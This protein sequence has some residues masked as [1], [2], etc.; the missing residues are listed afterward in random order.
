[1]PIREF[2]KLSPVPSVTSYGSTNDNK[3]DSN[4]NRKSTKLNNGSNKN[5]KLNGNR[6]DSSSSLTSN[7][8]IDSHIELIKSNNKR[9]DKELMSDINNI[10]TI[11]SANTSTTMSTINH[12]PSNDET[13]ILKICDLEYTTRRSSSTS[14]INSIKSNPDNNKIMV[15]T[16]IRTK[17]D[18]HPISSSPKRHH[19]SLSSS[20]VTSS[21]TT[22]ATSTLDLKSYQKHSPRNQHS[23]NKCNCSSCNSK[24]LTLDK[25][26]KTKSVG[27]Q[28]NANNAYDPWIKQN[29][30]N[31]KNGNC[32]IFKNSSTNQKSTNNSSNTKIIVITD[33]FKKKA[34]NQEV[35]IDSKRKILRYMK[36]NKMLNSSRSMDDVRVTTT[37]LLNQN[38]LIEN[39]QIDNMNEHQMNSSVLSIN[40]LNSNPIEHSDNDKRQKA[41][42]KSFDNISLLSNEL[43]ALDNVGSVELIFISDEF[44]NKV[45]DQNV[46]VLKNCAKIATINKQLNANN[47]M[48]ATTSTARKKI[49]V[50]TDEFC[51]KSIDNKNI[52]IVDGPKGNGRTKCSKLNRQSSGESS[53]DD[54]NNKITSRAFR[55]YDEE[56]EHLESKEIK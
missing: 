37:K 14:V 3:S 44:L 52:V 9:S 2:D 16:K 20:N 53:V 31:A 50:V 27:T 22:C 33:D 54:V 21:T 40:N 19:S 43:D 32:N 34:L 48:M 39:N 12:K 29:S 30:T 47:D 18:P 24:S 15:K 49:V 38:E 23:G 1:M 8:Q 26:N 7:N 28:H 46:I 13:L 4:I 11:S 45:S 36:T 5:D 42:S 25:R 35:L 55:S 6:N 17:T 41:I 10:S 56:T 51:R